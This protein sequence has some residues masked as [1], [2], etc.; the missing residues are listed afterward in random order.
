MQRASG[1]RQLDLDRAA[2]ERAAFSPNEPRLLHAVQV[3]GE[4]RAFDP[5]RAGEVE[6]SAPPLA[7]E[8]VQD[9]PDRNRAAS[10]SECAVECSPDRLGG[11]REEKAKRWSVRAH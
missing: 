11:C 6:L 7:L 9:Q 4:G 5:D 2:V 10:F 1:A 8:R 3:T